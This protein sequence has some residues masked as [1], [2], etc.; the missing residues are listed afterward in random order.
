MS[1]LRGARHE[2]VKVLI[3]IA[4]D[5]MFDFLLVCI[6]Q[7]KLDDSHEMLSL[8]SHVMPSLIF[9]ENDKEKN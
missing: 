4:A 6:I 7:R 2:W 9:T 1:L 3:T 5:N 8:I